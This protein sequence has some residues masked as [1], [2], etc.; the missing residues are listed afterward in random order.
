MN[1]YEDIIDTNDEHPVTRYTKYIPTLIEIARAPASPLIQDFMDSTTIDDTLP[2]DPLVAMEYKVVQLEQKLNSSHKTI[3]DFRAY[4]E[5]LVK[6]LNEAMDRVH[7]L[8]TEI[9][10][11]KPNPLPDAD[12]LATESL[13]LKSENVTLRAQLEAMTNAYDTTLKQYLEYKKHVRT[14]VLS[15]CPMLIHE[16]RL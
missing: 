4:S 5:H 15:V 7:A 11:R 16:G 1:N 10:I 13:V 6:N 12:D 14:T 9:G 2:D 3:E 8:E